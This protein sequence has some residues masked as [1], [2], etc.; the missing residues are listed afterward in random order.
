MHYDDTTGR[1]TRT[2]LR[3]VTDID[4]DFRG[5]EC[6]P[7]MVGSY[8]QL[9]KPA[10]EFVKA[11][12]RV[13]KLDP[14]AEESVVVLRRQLLAQLG[15]KEFSEE[16]EVATEYARSFIL[17]DLICAFCS[18][19]RDLDLCRDERACVPV[20]GW[21]HVGGGTH[22]DRDDGIDS[23]NNPFAHDPPT[24]TE[25]LSEDPEH[26]WRCPHCHNRYDTDRIEQ[27]LVES[28]QRTLT[29]Y[30]LQDVRCLKC[31]R[32]S[33]LVMAETCK[34]AGKLV[35]D[36]LPEAFTTLL[37]TLRRVAVHF[38]LQY[39]KQTV[40]FALRIDP[41]EEAG[42]EADVEGVAAQLEQHHLLESN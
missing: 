17:A 29:R 2:L 31:R 4:N 3:M 25:L 5:P 22:A 23:K 26:W 9:S 42:E 32:V 33:T 24:P 7:T 14:A 34:C 1:L 15:T 35:G 18:H 39:L 40:D 21:L 10:L 30:A 19:C 13:L 27:L 28:V 11:V 16:G 20:G 6:F 38:G 8:R 41:A 36:E 12:C 37:G